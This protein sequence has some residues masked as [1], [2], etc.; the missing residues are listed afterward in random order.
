MVTDTC[1]WEPG[2]ELVLCGKVLLGSQ[3]RQV[4]SAPTSAAGTPAEPQP[5]R[6]VGQ[7]V[8]V[9][10]VLTNTLSNRSQD[11][12]YPGLLHK[13]L[14][15]QGRRTLIYES[16]VGLAPVPKVR[17][18][19]RKLLYSPYTHP[20]HVRANVP[21]NRIIILQPVKRA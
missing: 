18:P 12:Y 19:R 7:N 8:S 10:N 15:Q 1:R 21:Y 20:T 16:R 2:T 13:R 5:P 6:T 3:W 11:R 14:K 4:C 9:S 17:M